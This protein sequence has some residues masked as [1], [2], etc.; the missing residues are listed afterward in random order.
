LLPAQRTFVL[1]KSGGILMLQRPDSSEYAPYFAPFVQLVPEGRFLDIYKQQTEAALTL[2]KNVDEERQYFRYADGKWTLK[3][4]LGHI[5]DS[6][7]V[8]SY[9]VLRVARGDQTPLPGFDENLFTA[10]SNY[11]DRTWIDLLEEY[12]ATHRSTL[13]LYRG[14]SSEAWTKLGTVSQVE[15]TARALAYSSLGHELRHVDTIRTKYLNT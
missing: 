10:G 4:V 6:D 12:E 2:L 5:I 15:T 1:S 8:F 11:N 3:E 14:L 7:R 9:R 13:C